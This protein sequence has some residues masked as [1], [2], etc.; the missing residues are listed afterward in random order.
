LTRSLRDVVNSTTVDVEEMTIVSR[1][2]Q[3]VRVVA[4]RRRNSLVRNHHAH[5]LMKADLMK[6][7]LMNV[8][9]LKH[10]DKLRD[11]KSADKRTS[12][13]CLMSKE[14]AA[15]ATEDSTTTEATESAANSHTAA[16]METK[17]T[18][19]LLKSAKSFVTMQLPCAI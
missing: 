7:D 16:V 10:R 5:D 4:G 2:K 8:D 11:L 6:A 17:I 13:C 14:A 9:R 3:S 15:N 1:R 19:R 18:S 12:A